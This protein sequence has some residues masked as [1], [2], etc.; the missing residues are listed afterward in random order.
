MP[1]SKARQ[2]EERALRRLA[3]DGDVKSLRVAA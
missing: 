3:A 2:A 1:P